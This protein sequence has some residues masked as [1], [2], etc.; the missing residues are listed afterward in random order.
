MRFMRGKHHPGLG[1]T[2]DG[3][4]NSRNSASGG[5]AVGLEPSLGLNHVVS[6]WVGITANHPLI[7]LTVSSL[8]PVVAGMACL[9]AVH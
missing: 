8:L 4:E 2:I 3:D 9:V 5:E 7:V 6:A 1:I